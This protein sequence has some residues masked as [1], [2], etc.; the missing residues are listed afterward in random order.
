MLLPCFA[1]PCL[2]SLACLARLARCAE[3]PSARD[4]F[5]CRP[6]LAPTRHIS[7]ARHTMRGNHY[8]G[9]RPLTARHARGQNR[10][11]RTNS[12]VVIRVGGVSLHWRCALENGSKHDQPTARTVASGT[13]KL[14][15][16]LCA[17]TCGTRACAWWECQSIRQTKAHAPNC[18]P[19]GWE[20]FNFGAQLACVCC[21]C[22]TCGQQSA[23]VQRGFCENFINCAPFDS[24]RALTFA[25]HLSG[26]SS[27]SYYR[28]RRVQWSAARAG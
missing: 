17:A 8:L 18:R 20:Q 26:H 5:T 13:H 4:K 7:S 16:D 25:C 2:V 23:S 9:A 3:L 14:R 1:L 12:K 21:V 11:T 22:L 27:T 6:S 28:V 24:M 15:L 10:Q 19:V